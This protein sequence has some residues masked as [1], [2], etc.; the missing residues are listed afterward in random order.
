MPSI[1]S[2]KRVSQLWWPPVEVDN[3][4]EAPAPEND[5]NAHLIRIR[6]GDYVLRQTVQDKIQ[7]GPS[8]VP[9]ER[10]DYTN[11]AKLIVLMIIV[12]TVRNVVVWMS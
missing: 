5:L 3:P 11:R 6:S 9:D 4:G 1:T 2:R 10:R 8:E 7:V 12:V